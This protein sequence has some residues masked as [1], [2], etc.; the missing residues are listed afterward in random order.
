MKQY[1]VSNVIFSVILSI[2][3]VGCSR[4]APPPP[5]PA[6]RIPVGSACAQTTIACYDEFARQPSKVV[7]FRDASRWQTTDLTWRVTEFYDTL[8]MDGQIEAAERAFAQWADASN[9]TLTRVDSGD[10]NITIA[11]VGGQHGDDFPFDGPGMNLAHA[12]FP[13]SGRP[14]DIHMCSDEMWTLDAAANPDGFDVFTAMLHEIGHA[15]G[16]E[17]TLDADAVMAPS[18]Q[19]GVEGLTATDI[20][21]IQVLYGAPGETLPDDI[22]QSAAFQ[23]FCAD[24][25]PANIIDLGDP[26]T[27]GDGIPD[28]IEVFLL[29]TDAI[30]DDTDG[31]QVTDFREIFFDRTDPRDRLLFNPGSVDITLPLVG[32]DQLGL[33]FSV[34]GVARAFFNLSESTT[35]ANFGILPGVDDNAFIISLL[36]F[37]GFEFSNPLSPPTS[38]SSY[39]VNITFENIAAVNGR[40]EFDEAEVFVSMLNSNTDNVTGISSSNQAFFCNCTCSQFFVQSPEF[41][42]TDVLGE[43]APAGFFDLTLSGGR[44]SGS[45]DISLRDPISGNVLRLSGDLNVSEEFTQSQ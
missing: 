45:L 12:F 28:T 17:H 25:D 20:D 44:V 10:A 39:Q 32:E 36:S 23:A 33:T 41:L 13:G 2:L 40:R 6:L 29:N 8:S 5:P 1:L 30:A 4:P 18:Y 7:C 9:L 26:D 24:A 14:G 43:S 31:D 16:I 35:V 38:I 3:H 21:A 11:F 22:Q 15:L 19:N 34:N 27:D 42:C 37:D